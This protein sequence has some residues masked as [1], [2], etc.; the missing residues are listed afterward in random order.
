MTVK[1][2]IFSAPMVRAILAR[3]K[4]QTRRVLKPQP[5]VMNGGAPLYDGRGSYSIEGGWKRIPYAPGD[6][7]W[8]REKIERANGEAVGYPADGTWLPN[9]PWSWA[10]ASLPSIHMPRWA[11]RLTLDVIGVKIER[12]QDIS[13]ADARS[14]GCGLYVPGHGFVQPEDLAEG[15]SNYL[16]PRMGFEVIWTEIN[17]SG[18][19]AA[20]PWVV[21]IT[22]TVHKINIDEL[23]RQREAA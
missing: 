4:T 1:P 22:F 18:S 6:L 13:E 11:S 2:I 7:L 14:E 8:V 16:S 20:N 9:T 23:L 10:R 12:L 19:W 21:A 15:Y 5:N 3:T 17:G